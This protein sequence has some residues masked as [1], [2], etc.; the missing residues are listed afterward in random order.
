M[1]SLPF[2]KKWA[3][4][5]SVHWSENA[6]KTYRTNKKNPSASALQCIDLHLI[7]TT[8]LSHNFEP[9]IYSPHYKSTE[10]FAG[11]P[12]RSNR[13]ITPI[14]DLV[15]NQ[16]MRFKNATLRP[17]SL[18]V[19][20]G[21]SVFWVH[22]ILR[23]KPFRLNCFIFQWAH[24]YPFTTS[25]SRAPVATSV[26]ALTTLTTLTSWSPNKLMGLQNISP[27]S[28]SSVIQKTVHSRRVRFLKH[29]CISYIIQLDAGD[30]VP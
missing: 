19:F 11:F 14:R 12:R 24:F 17:P 3:I 6:G 15:Y 9:G 1:V 28:R 20:K 18:L 2:M 25:S 26:S 13:P 21:G 16:K 27:G 29:F 7:N 10:P 8:C 30:R 4:V 22:W 23:V 5:E